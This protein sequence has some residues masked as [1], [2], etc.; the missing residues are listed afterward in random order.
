[1][2]L[3]DITFVHSGAEHLNNN[4]PL[5][6]GTSFLRSPGLNPQLNFTYDYR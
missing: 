3:I 2:Y 6:N 5:S 1:M 4:K